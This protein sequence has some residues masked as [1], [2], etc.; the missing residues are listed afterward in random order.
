M[1]AVADFGE[2]QRLIMRALLLRQA[3]EAK[4]QKEAP[5]NDDAPPRDNRRDWWHRVPAAMWTTPTRD[6]DHAREN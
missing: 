6:D 4:K 5:R 1:S 3:E 2:P